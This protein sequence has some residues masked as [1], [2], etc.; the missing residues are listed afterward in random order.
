MNNVVA[1]PKLARETV[2]IPDQPE[3]LN[4]SIAGA[5]QSVQILIHMLSDLHVDPDSRLRA[6]LVRRLEHLR[7]A[8]QRPAPSGEQKA[9]ELKEVSDELKA[10][11]ELLP[12]MKDDLLVDV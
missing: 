6:Y 2:A 11:V 8:V 3:D 12:Y 5:W 1:H 4:A 7:D 10:L 9:V